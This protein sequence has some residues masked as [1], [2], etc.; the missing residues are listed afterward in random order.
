MLDSGESLRQ[1]L[2]GREG[3]CNI[4]DFT[5]K[6]DVG[7]GTSGCVF[8]VGFLRFQVHYSTP[9][10][11]ASLK[12]TLWL[13]SPFLHDLHVRAQVYVNAPGFPCPSAVFALKVP[14]RMVHFFPPSC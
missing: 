10:S 11:F 12:M 2:E 14:W 13:F 5:W 9:P 4:R 1:W 3:G 6:S 8:E 7:M